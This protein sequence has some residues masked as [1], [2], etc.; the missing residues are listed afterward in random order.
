M[1]ATPTGNFMAILLPKDTRGALGEDARACDSRSLFFDKFAD[2]LAK[3]SGNR[4]PRKTWFKSVIGRKPLRVKVDSWARCLGEL[5]LTP[6]DILLVKLQSRLMVNMAGGVMENA[7]LCLDRFGVSYIPGSA[8]KGCARRMAIQLLAEAREKNHHPEVLARL[9]ADIALVFGWG[10]DD[11]RPDQNKHGHLKSDFVY[12]IGCEKWLKVFREVGGLLLQTQTERH[13]DLSHFAG[14]VAFLAAYPQALSAN[15]LELDVVTCHHPRYYQGE[16]DLATD[17]EEPNPVTFIA[18]A[19]GPTFAFA[20]LPLR[21]QRESL[22]QP[23]AKLHVLARNWLHQGLETFGLGA[24]TAAGYGWFNETG[25][26]T[27]PTTSSDETQGV[28]ARP[29]VSTSSEHALIT[30]WRG[31]TQPSNFRVFRP[32]LAALTDDEEL[33]R[34]FGAV[35]PPGELARL[36]RSNPYWQS[37]TAHPDGIA[38]LKRLK[39]ELR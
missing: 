31:K 25:I 38:I 21:A 32:L 15:D 24:K 4:T 14:A 28:V 8:V 9:L 13:E 36:K 10:Q 5:G 1:M 39:I 29:A 18:V 23:G 16:L 22:S 3:D 35:M 30:Q 12:A 6:D 7:G 19:A 26:Q 33:K 27:T 17:D 11:W 20:T 34:V 2:P 37:F